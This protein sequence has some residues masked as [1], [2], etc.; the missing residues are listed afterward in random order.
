MLDT[1]PQW[2]YEYYYDYMIRWE[3][4][5]GYAVESW[6]KP[7]QSNHIERKGQNDT[8]IQIS[9]KTIE[10]RISEINPSS[11]SSSSSSSLSSS[12]SSSKMYVRYCQGH[13]KCCEAEAGIWGMCITSGIRGHTTLGGRRDRAFA[14]LHFFVAMPALKKIRP[15]RLLSCPVLLDY[16]FK[17]SPGNIDVFR[18]HMVRMMRLY[19]RKS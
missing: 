3:D 18:H 6:T 15:N 4:I 12:S 10:H 5:H 14:K 13:R 11:S 2:T 7:T 19:C 17:A 16:I 9:K 1:A 8:R